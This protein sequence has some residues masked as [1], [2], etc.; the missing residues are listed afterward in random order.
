MLIGKYMQGKFRKLDS[1]AYC[2]HQLIHEN[3]VKENVNQ[4]VFPTTVMCTQLWLITRIYMTEHLWFCSSYCLVI[5]SKSVL[6][7]IGK[8]KSSCF[9]ITLMETQIK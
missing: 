9:G 1:F 2:I 4:C 3:T 8:R 7:K 6:W 5:N